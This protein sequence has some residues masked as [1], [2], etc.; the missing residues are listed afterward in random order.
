ME[1]APACGCYSSCLLK[2]RTLAICRHAASGAP[3]VRLAAGVTV[4]ELAQY[5]TDHA[6]R[7]LPLAPGCSGCGQA[8]D[9]F[10]YDAVCLL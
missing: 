3:L 7:A 4:G 1:T 9:N 2:L 5:V 6:V 10:V 8:S